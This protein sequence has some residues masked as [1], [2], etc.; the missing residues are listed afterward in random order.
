M[1]FWDW[2]FGRFDADLDTIRAESRLSHRA[3]KINT[4]KPVYRAESTYAQ[5]YRIVAVLFR[6]FEKKK[7]ARPTPPSPHSGLP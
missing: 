2:R 1:R 5:V 4:I 6:S 7:I 3:N